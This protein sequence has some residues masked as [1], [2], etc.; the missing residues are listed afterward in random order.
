MPSSIKYIIDDIIEKEW[1]MFTNV[2][3]EGGRAS[4][5][6][7]YRTFYIMR[8]S[9]F[10]AW[11]TSSLLFYNNDLDAAVSEGRS[12]PTEKYAYMMASTAPEEYEKI[13]GVLPEVSDEKE[14]LISEIISLSLKETEEFFNKYP[15][16]RNSGRPLYKE[17]DRLFTSIETYTSGELKTY[18]ENTLASYLKHIKEL[19]SR[20]ESVVFKIYENT[21][22]H[23]GY[24]DVASAERSLKH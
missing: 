10:E 7:D 6:D 11:D 20:G 3:N 5:Q 16:F 19:E 13:K 23:Y 17:D 15:G 24:E 8:A 12:L 9:Q 22:R 1:N 18:S 14:K 21:A 4:C 2:N